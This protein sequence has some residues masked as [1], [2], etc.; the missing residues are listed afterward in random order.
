V[1]LPIGNGEQYFNARTL[2]ESGR[3]E[4]LDQ[5]QFTAQYLTT[6]IDALLAASSAAPIDGSDLDLSAAEKIVALGEF[7]MAK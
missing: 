5:S 7:A 2:V 4:I 6:H 3:A 1:P